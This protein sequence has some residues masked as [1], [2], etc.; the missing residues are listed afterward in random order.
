MKQLF[1]LS[2]AIFTVLNIYAQE[3]EE[4][5][6]TV[7]STVTGNECAKN[8]GQGKRENGS[9]TGFWRYFHPNCQISRSGNYKNG[10]KN[11]EWKSYFKDGSLYSVN[12]YKDGKTHGE[13]IEYYDYARLFGEDKN[14]KDSIKIKSIVNYTEGTKNGTYLKYFAKKSF[15]SEKGAYKNGLKTGLWESYHFNSTTKEQEG[16]YELGKEIGLWKSYFKTGNLFYTI[17]KET[18]EVKYFDIN[19]GK[20]EEEGIRIERKR[21]G[22]WKSYYPNGKLKF[23][24]IYEQGKLWNITKYLNE[25]GKR[26]KIGSFKN[27]NGI[28]NEYDE[29]GKV[30]KHYLFEDGKK[31]DTTYLD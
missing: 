5:Q 24:S 13:Q 29:T 6:E 30:V 3:K 31:I 27:G 20:I 25:N 21:V 10:E 26:L 17:N 23:I 8:R 12:N 2:I 22:T 1:S 4:V 9:K 15:L 16:E 7:I 19:T 18:N 11:G 14:V 28:L